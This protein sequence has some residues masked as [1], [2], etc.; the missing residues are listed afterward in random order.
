MTATARSSPL[1]VRAGPRDPA[2]RRVG[3][4]LAVLLA[5]CACTPIGAGVGVAATAGVAASQERGFRR[6]VD[7][8]VIAAD[9]GRRLLAYDVGAFARLRVDVHEGQVLLTGAV[10]DPETRIEA[11][12]LAWQAEG[13]DRVLNEIQ[14]TDQ[15]SL[16]NRSRDKLIL[17]NLRS[18]L[19]LDSEIQSINYNIDVVN[20]TVYLLGVAQSQN[21]LARVEAH[22]RNQSYVRR[23]ISHVRV[24]SGASAAPAF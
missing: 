22:A 14:V 17:G 8:N 19:L 3:C 20:G 5:L 18:D 13:V 11:V 10:T 15:S 4:A 23:V 16:L 24:K 2:A 21:E 7:D 9:I 6:A 12:R 1:P